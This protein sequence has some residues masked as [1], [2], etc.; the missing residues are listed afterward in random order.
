[1]MGTKKVGAFPSPR[2]KAIT[3]VALKKQNA[4][5]KLLSVKNIFSPGGGV[6]FPARNRAQWKEKTED[7]RRAYGREKDGDQGR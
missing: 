2:K 5:E 4:S 3:I 6:A 1:M 7:P